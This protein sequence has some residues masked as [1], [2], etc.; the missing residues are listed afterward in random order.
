[1]SVVGLSADLN[2]FLKV[3]EVLHAR[4]VLGPSFLQ[5]PPDYSPRY[6]HD[7]ESFLARLPR[8]LPW[9]VELRQPVGLTMPQRAAFRCDAG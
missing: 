6:Q 3:A 8:H 7:L 1:M 9:A 5:L 4:G 2:E